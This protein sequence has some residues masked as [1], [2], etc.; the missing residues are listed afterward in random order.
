MSINGVYYPHILDLSAVT[1]IGEVARFDSNSFDPN[2]EM[3][4]R[5]AGSDPYDCFVSASSADPQIDFSTPSLKPILQA[6]ETQSIAKKIENSPDAAVMNFRKASNFS[7]RDGLD[8]A[9]HVQIAF[10]ELAMLFWESITARESEDAVISGRLLA[11]RKLSTEDPWVNRGDVSLIPPN[12]DSVYS[13]GP[14]LFNGR[15]LASVHQIN[16]TNN[17]EVYS[18]RTAINP[19]DPCYRNIKMF[20]PVVRCSTNDLAEIVQE[21]GTPLDEYGG[22]Q[23]FKLQVFLRRRRRTNFFYEDNLSEHIEIRCYGGWKGVTTVSGVEE[24]EANIEF[25]CA[26]AVSGSGRVSSD[27]LLTRLIDTPIPNTDANAL[28]DISQPA[29]QSVND[30]DHIFFTPELGA[31]GLPAAVGAN[32][33]WEVNTLPTGLS[34]D[35]VSGLISGTISGTGTTTVQL[36][37]RNANG[38][39]VKS[40]DFISS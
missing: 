11:T 5:K 38:T 28:P 30:G 15:H 1:G 7:I 24:A 9:V 19:K 40:F 32:P 3:T 6:C 35:P 4:K 33:A 8:S 39:S 34:I 16:W 29:N 14:V 12:C 18:R 23:M 25:H 13:L 10:Q 20:R 36:T 37:A 22:E 27:Y 26:Q 21:N 17:V 31:G 2:Y